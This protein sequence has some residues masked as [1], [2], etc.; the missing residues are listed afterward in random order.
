MCFKSLFSNFFF[1]LGH[2]PVN[3]FEA[4]VH[5]LVLTSALGG[6]SGPDEVRH[7]FKDLAGSKIGDEIPS[8]QFGAQSVLVEENECDIAHFFRHIP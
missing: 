2:Y 8:L 4:L 3:S 5:L 6:I 1:E 7:L